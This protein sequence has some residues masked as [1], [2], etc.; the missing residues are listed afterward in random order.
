MKIAL[1]VTLISIFIATVFLNANNQS[2]ELK[3]GDKA[4]EFALYDQD[5]KLHKLSD[6][7][8]QRLIIYYFPKADTPG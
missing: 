1:L 6:Y 3:V 4:P 8:G 5:N 7:K 2:V